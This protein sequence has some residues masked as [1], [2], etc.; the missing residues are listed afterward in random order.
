M[1][2]ITLPTEADESGSLHF[3]APKKVEDAPLRKRKVCFH[4]RI[5]C[6]RFNT[7]PIMNPDDIWY[8]K[9]E[10]ASLRK[11]NK[12]LQSLE[13]VSEITSFAG[14]DDT[15][16]ISYVGLNS[17]ME[18]RQ[19]INRIKEAKTCVLDEQLQQEEDF[20]KEFYTTYGFKLEHEFIAEFYSFHSIRAAK[21]AHMKGLK[22]SFHVE[23]LSAQESANIGGNHRPC[24]R[25]S[26]SQRAKATSDHRPGQNRSI[27]SADSLTARLTTPAA[28]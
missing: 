20:F 10:L 24:S 21:V 2:N 9:Q 5:Q 3:Q 22:L 28:A 27:R 23:S 12:H 8:S 13:M 26:C 18:R 16:E 1:E 17:E 7:P 11:Q 14:N 6:R 4:S 19:R 15:E 25:H